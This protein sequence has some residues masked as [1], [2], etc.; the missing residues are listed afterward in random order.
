[1][2]PK[3]EA[4]RM[5]ESMMWGQGS[6]KGQRGG[7]Q[8]LAVVSLMVSSVRRKMSVAENRTLLLAADYPEMKSENL[9]AAIPGASGPGIWLVGPSLCLLK[10]KK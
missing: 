1:M 10:V 2:E 6:L 9:L 4:Q 3:S 5:E 7:D 8:L